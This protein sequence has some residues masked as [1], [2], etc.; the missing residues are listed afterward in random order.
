MKSFYKGAFNFLHRLVIL[1]RKDNII[2]QNEKEL[3][4]EISQKFGFDSVLCKESLNK[5]LFEKKID[6]S[7]PKFSS[8]RETIK[9]ILDAI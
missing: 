1:I 4:L 6:I 7:S 5:F 2:H 9:F 8:N 3:M